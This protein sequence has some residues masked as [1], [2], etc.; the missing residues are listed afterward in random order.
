VPR[1]KRPPYE[2]T[3]CGNQPGTGTNQALLGRLN[4]ILDIGAARTVM[5]L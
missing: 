3:T 5:Q 4:F 2:S 1:S